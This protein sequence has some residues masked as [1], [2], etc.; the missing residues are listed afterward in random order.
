MRD[1][2]TAQLE[3][4]VQYQH[5]EKIINYIQNMNKEKIA[6][7]FGLEIDSYLA[8]KKIFDQNVLQAA[9]ELLDDSSFAKQ[10]DQLPFLAGSKIM[11]IGDS[12][13]DDSNSWFEIL[14][15]ILHLHRPKDSFIFINNGVTGYT[16]GQLLRNITTYIQQKPDWVFCLV[17]GNDVLRIGNAVG[18]NYVSVDETTKNLSAIRDITQIQ[19]QATWVWMTPPQI[20]ENRASANPYFQQLQL[21]WSNDDLQ[22]IRERILQF[23]E[24][25]IDIQDSFGSPVDPDWMLEDGIHPSLEGQKQIVKSVVNRLTS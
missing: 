17:G 15:Q 6:N 3:K 21:S 11:A 22:D 4:L 8:I 13:T 19:T 12:I 10:I 18:K 5:P 24:F 23:P 25:V 9:Q 16:S 7:L 20:I 1:K 14:K 2:K